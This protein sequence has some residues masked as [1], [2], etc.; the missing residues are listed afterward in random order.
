MEEKN[1]LG[2]GQYLKISV[3]AGQNEQNYN[4]SFTDP[5]FLGYRISAGFDAYYNVYDKWPGKRPFDETVVGGTLR[6]GL[7]ITDNLTAQ[8]NYKLFQ[9]SLTQHQSVYPR[10]LPQRRHAHLVDRRWVHLLDDRQQ[11]RSA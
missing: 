7:P 6:F 1:F 4:L 9:D 8:F 11:A 3:G 10:L 5:Y 2:R